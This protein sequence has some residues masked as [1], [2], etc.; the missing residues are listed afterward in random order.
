LA[1]GGSVVA[2]AVNVGGVGAR[3]SLSVRPER[4]SLLTSD[5][6]DA[7]F[8]RLPGTLKDLIY[9]GDHTLAVLAAPGNNEF[10][11]KLP[12]GAYSGL[13]QGQA[14]TIAFRPEDCRALDPV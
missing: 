13:S 5:D 11:V 12:A 7:A 1:A 10:M 2:T 9:V 14:V 6:G 3:T 8:N 4:V